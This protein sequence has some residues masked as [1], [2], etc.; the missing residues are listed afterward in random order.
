MLRMKA[1]YEKQ[2]EL[3]NAQQSL[4]LEEGGNGK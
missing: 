1:L 2:M 4:N 3:A